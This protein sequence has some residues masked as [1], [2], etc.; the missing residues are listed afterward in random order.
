LDRTIDPVA[1]VLHE[2]TYQAMI[3]D[4]IDIKKGCTYSYTYN[5]GNKDVKKEVLL[6][7]Y[8]FLW[9]KLRHMHIADCINKV[10]DD[11]N[12]FLKTNKAV[13]LNNAKRTG[14]TSLKEMASAMKELPQFQEMF[15]KYS[16]HI[17]LAGECMDNY[18]GK[19]LEKIAMVE[20]DIA[21]GTGADGRVV[22]HSALTAELTD[23][24]RDRSISSED[25]MRLLIAYIAAEDS[26]P[27]DKEELLDAAGLS[28]SETKAVENVSL[29]GVS[30]EKGSRDRVQEAKQKRKGRN[31]DEEVPYAVSRYV[32]VIKRLLQD[33]FEDQLPT[34]E[35]PYFGE[36]PRGGGGAGRKKA[37]SLKSGTRKRTAS[38]KKG[39]ERN[40]EDMGAKVVV[41]VAG[42]VTFSEVRSAYELTESAEREVIIGSSCLLTPHRF[43]TSLG[44]LSGGQRRRDSSSSSD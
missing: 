44:G 24:L 22:K 33:L 38:S 39:K 26:K 11:F 43:L 23:L 32:P 35:F 36:E 29:L 10:I 34:S 6:D 16:L 9:P 21:T 14:V 28:S 1:P 19:E 15:A 27:T 13:K 4:L 7:E 5:N 12:A 30:L 2:F 41:F 3:Y 17:R 8:D 31:T 42:G 37:T 40:S 25:K 18:K 20:Q